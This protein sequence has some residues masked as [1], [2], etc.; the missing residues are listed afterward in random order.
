MLA[1][2]VAELS[3]VLWDMVLRQGFGFTDAFGA[4]VIYL[5][6]WVFAVLTIGILVFMEGLSAFLHALRLHWLVNFKIH[7]LY[8]QYFITIY[9]NEMGMLA[10]WSSIQ[11]STLAKVTRSCRFRSIA[12]WRRLGPRTA[13]RHYILI[14]V[15]IVHNFCDSRVRYHHNSY[16]TTFRLEL[17]IHVALFRILFAFSVGIRSHF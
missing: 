16:A 4:I 11:S 13:N 8:S 5:I 3:E 14:R 12:F 1:F 10:G 15:C 17:N 2:I 9:G 6:F 7:M